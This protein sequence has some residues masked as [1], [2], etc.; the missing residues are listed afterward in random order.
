MVGLGAPA[1]MLRS[2]EARGAEVR[3]AARAVQRSRR[4]QGRTRR[5]RPDRIPGRLLLGKGVSPVALFPQY[6]DVQELAG[7]DRIHPADLWP[8]D[9]RWIEPETPGRRAD[10][11]LRPA[12][13]SRMDQAVLR[14]VKSATSRR[15][16]DVIEVQPRPGRRQTARQP[17]IFWK[18]CAGYFEA[19]ALGL[20]PVRPVR[21]AR[22]LAR[23]AA[24]RHAGQGRARR[25]RPP[26]AGPAVLLRAGGAGAPGRRAGAGQPCARPTGW[27]ASSRSTT[28]PARSAASIRCC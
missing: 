8:Y 25:V 2:M 12:V 19:L 26:R 6:K 13:R 15:R 28:R 14:I 11:R 9:W 23:A 24:V 5:L 18:L 27:T 21:Q 10:A 3:R 7:S 16:P 4:R 22:R 1:H 17:K 20:L